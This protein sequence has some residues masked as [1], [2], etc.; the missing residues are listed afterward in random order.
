MVWLLWLGC[1]SG[2]VDGPWRLT[3]QA[4]TAWDC[5]NDG[6]YYAAGEGWGVAVWL[7]DK[8][9]SMDLGHEDGLDDC[10]WNEDTGAILCT[11]TRV[12]DYAGALDA[13]VT[14]VDQLDATFTSDARLNGTL[15]TS[16]TCEG[17]DCGGD[18]AT[19]LAPDPLVGFPCEGET[20]IHAQPE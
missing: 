12:D 2:P 20:P 17:D 6:D 1:A 3:V 9:V 5:T 7:E 10:T 13:V 16:L 14:W 19:L 8:V 18:A 11:E 15:S 4:D